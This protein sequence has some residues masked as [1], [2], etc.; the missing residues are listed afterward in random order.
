[1]RLPPLL[2]RSSQYFPCSKFTRMNSPLR[3]KL[4]RSL[5]V[6]LSNCTMNRKRTSRCNGSQSRTGLWR[7]PGLCEDQDS[8]R[9]RQAFS[10]F[11]ALTILIAVA[12][13]LIAPSIDMPDTVLHEH[14]VASHSAGGHASG[15][16]MSSGI[17]TAIEVYQNESAS[18]SLDILHSPNSGYNLSSVVLRC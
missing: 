1:M 7:I 11:V 4:I 5:Y 12:T 3:E 9:F 17:S 16:L 18:R 10:V 6:S 13:T 8:A 15:S 2:P 14:H